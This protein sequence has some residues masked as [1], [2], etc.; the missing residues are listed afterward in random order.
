MYGHGQRACLSKRLCSGLA[1]EQLWICLVIAGLQCLGGIQ[2]LAITNVTAASSRW[3][4]QSAAAALWLHCFQEI[5]S[6]PQGQ[7]QDTLG[8]FVSFS[9]PTA[10]HGLSRELYNEDSQKRIEETPL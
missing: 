2:H 1:W 5:V 7:G 3:L 6:L 8:D 10:Q 9:L 4:L